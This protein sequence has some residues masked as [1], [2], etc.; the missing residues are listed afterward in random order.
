[1]LGTEQEKIKDERERERER[2]RRGLTANL[3]KERQG[4]EEEGK[5]GQ[6]GSF[7]EY[8]SV[9]TN[10][11]EKVQCSGDSAKRHPQTPVTP[12]WLS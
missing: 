2:T 9:G 10:G 3:A 6:A 5:E 8:S 12:Q 1:M 7:E 4:Q 11:Q